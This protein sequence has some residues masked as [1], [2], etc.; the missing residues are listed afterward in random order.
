MKEVNVW[1]PHTTSC[2]PVPRREMKVS[3]KN[4]ESLGEIDWGI[5]EN[6]RRMGLRKFSKR[7]VTQVGWRLLGADMEQWEKEWCEGCAELSD[8]CGT[9]WHLC[10]SRRTELDI[11]CW[12][13]KRENFIAGRP[14]IGEYRNFIRLYLDRGRSKFFVVGEREPIAR[15][16]TPTEHEIILSPITKSA[17]RLGNSLIKTGRVTAHQEINVECYIRKW[18]NKGVSYKQA[19]ARR[20]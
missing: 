12:V 2:T 9:H 16:S 8:S 18:H 7:F 20:I 6:L 17:E 19:T 1:I 5:A 11:N 14:K 15:T 4:S 10:I 13:D 3:N